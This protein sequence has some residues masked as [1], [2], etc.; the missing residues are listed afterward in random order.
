M[1]HSAETVASIR[2]LQADLKSIGAQASGSVA[3]AIAALNKKTVAIAGEAA[4]AGRGGRGG[5]GGG[6]GRGGAAP[7]GEANLVQISGE[8]GGLYGLIDSADAAPTAPQNAQL[9]QLEAAQTKQMAQ[10]TEIKTKD[11]PALNLQLKNANLPAIE[12]KTPAPADN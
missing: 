10:W 11:V 4:A 7:A 9:A 5:G 12:I 6:G 3:D 8:F 2:A 1:K